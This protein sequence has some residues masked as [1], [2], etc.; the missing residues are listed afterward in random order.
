[1]KNRHYKITAP[2][3][4]A[5][6]MIL[7]TATANAA[8]V[9]LQAQAFDKTIPY[10]TGAGAPGQTLAVANGDFET[11]DC[12]TGCVTDTT[13]GN[14]AVGSFAGWTVSGTGGVFQPLPYAIDPSV[15]GSAQVGWVTNGS[16]LSQP[17]TET[18][19]ADTIYTLSVDVG[20]RKDSTFTQARV[21]LYAGGTEV[22][23]ALVD[24]PA[25]SG[26][27]TA[28]VVVDTGVTPASGALE[29][30]LAGTGTQTE[31]D[32]VTLSTG[33]AGATVAMW[34]YSL[35]TDATFGSCG[36]ASSPGPQIDVPAGEGLIVH[37]NNTLPVATSLMIAGQKNAPLPV[38]PARDPDGRLKSFVPEVAA[39]ASGD[40][41]WTDL[42]PGAFLYQS[43]SNVALQVQM[44][45][46]GAVTR[47]A[48]CDDTSSTSPCAYPDVAYDASQVLVF[49]EIDPALHNPPKAANASKTGYVPRFFLINGEAFTGASA[50]AVADSVIYDG[51]PVTTNVVIA[52]G[53]FEFLDISDCTGVPNCNTD[54]VRGNWVAGSF[55]GWTLAG[56]G[57]LF[58]PTAAAIVLPSGAQIGWA[59]NGT[60]LSQVLSESA[61]ADTTY[62]LSVDVGMRL[63]TASTGATVALYAGGLEVGS[64]TVPA[65]TSS[66]W[67]TATVVVDTTGTAISGALE[68]RLTGSGGQTEFD[69]VTLN[70]TGPSA[71]SSRILLRMIN[72]GLENHAPQ[73]LGSYMDVIAEDGHRS[74]VHKT[75]NTVFL[76]AAKSMDLLFT[77]SEAGT[78]PLFDRRLRLV[79]DTALGGGMFYQIVVGGTP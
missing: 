2:V 49:S 70:R 66:G 74:P 68:I 14:Y 79:N 72:A 1:M 10:G 34:G 52:D 46:Y 50:S 36:T 78:Y 73:M 45:L 77:P 53:D 59:A 25:T 64:T 75:Q 67:Q 21:S 39:G 3:A 28:T 32:N 48:V 31:F 5:L 40:Y 12:T 35:C 29:I 8:E 55:S 51:A 30:R 37:L 17:L 26:W 20:M 42:T 4:V 15:A 63:D 69:N 47:D 18:A 60:T 43:G 27:Q 19:T 24:A 33:A 7:G 71:R 65:P 41:T 13:R 9:Y 61:A 62:T 57:G 38:N 16:S 11:P 54:A 58:R 22:G 23:F 76:P 56:S 6:A 44:G